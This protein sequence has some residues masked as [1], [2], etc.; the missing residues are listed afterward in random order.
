VKDVKRTARD[1]QAIQKVSR[2][3]RALPGARETTLDGPKGH[4]VTNWR[5]KARIFAELDERDVSKHLSLLVPVPP[6][7]WKAL[8]HAKP[9]RIVL[10]ASRLLRNWLGLVLDGDPNWEL[11]EVM[12]T[13]AHALE[14]AEKRA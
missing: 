6:A 4:P 12:I 13:Q 3:C 5:V 9:K 10:P 7:A 8:G 1:C 14:A 11:I 2:I